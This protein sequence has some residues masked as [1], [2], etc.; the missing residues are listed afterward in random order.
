MPPSRTKLV[1]AMNLFFGNKHP[2]I[3]NGGAPSLTR[4]D[5]AEMA[6]EIAR[7]SDDLVDETVRLWAGRVGEMVQY[8]VLEH[9]DGIDALREACV[10]RGLVQE[11]GEDGLQKLLAGAIGVRPWST[12]EEAS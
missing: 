8:G 1:M 2:E 3:Q 7:A 5:L 12:E 11:R 4:S 10:S 6:I 9:S